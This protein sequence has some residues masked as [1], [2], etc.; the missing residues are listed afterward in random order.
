MTKQRPGRLGRLGALVAVPVLGALTLS[1]CAAGETGGGSGGDAKSFTFTFP[2]ATNTESP[3]E[4][5]AKKYTGETGVKI[6]VRKLPNDGYQT[7]LRT[8]LQGGNAPDLMVVSPG[9]G[10]EYSVLPLAEA[11]LLEPLNDQSAK[12][13]PGGADGLFALDGKTY[14]QPTSLVPVGMAWNS[15]VADKTG[16][17]FPEDAG[18][19][20]NLCRTLPSNG[21]SFI[22]LAGSVAPNPGLMA[23]SVSATRVY[24]QTPDWNKQRAEG[25]VSFAQSQEWQD[26]LK[27]IEEMNQAGCFQKGAAGGGFDAITQG[28]GRGTSLGAFVPGGAVQEIMNNAPVT[29]QVRA[30]PPATGGKPYLL[31]S[32][33]YAFSIN[34]KANAAQKAAAQDFLNWLAKPDNAAQFTKIEGQVPIAGVEGAELAPQYEPVK[35]LLTK[36]D[37]APLPNLEWPNPAVYD[38]L[39]KGV[40]GLIA[41]RGNA[42][43]VLEAM[44]KAWER[45]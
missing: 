9:R 5:L 4:T 33:N 22:A 6:E 41:G 20:L 17:Q 40:Q 37:Y 13:V 29:L 27:T 39:A 16:V 18:A 19:M 25:K 21:K 45:K 32:A 2:T 11:K 36:G 8:Q 38:A 26:V 14:A 15:G 12:V 23:M 43:S 28:I 35:D 31:A 3:Y 34:A 24:A 7:T 42:Q 10:Q 44:D 30:F 1:A